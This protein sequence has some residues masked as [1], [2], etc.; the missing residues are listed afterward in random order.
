MALIADPILN[1]PFVEPARHFKFDDGG[2]TNEILT[3]PRPSSH[4]V[5]SAVR[6]LPPRYG[7][8]VLVRPRLGQGAFRVVVTEGYGRACA[9]TGE[10]SLPVLEAA[11]IKPFDAEGPHDIRN[12]LLPG[13]TSIAF[14]TRVTL[15]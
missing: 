10:H 2:I 1:S 6:E 5:P 3:G 4:F 14:L 11:H 13:P 9:V 12:G 7:E 15:R 8:P